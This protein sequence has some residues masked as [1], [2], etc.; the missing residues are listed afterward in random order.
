M[1]CRVFRSA[2]LLCR[3]G[4]LL[5]EETSKLVD[6]APSGIRKRAWRKSSSIIMESLQ[7]KAQKSKNLH[8]ISCN[9]REEAVEM[10]DRGCSLMG[11]IRKRS[12]ELAPYLNLILLKIR[13]N[14]SLTICSKGR[15]R[16]FRTRTM[17]SFQLPS[18]CILE[19]TNWN[20]RGKDRS[21]M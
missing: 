21:K 11:C 10:G 16:I 14:T 6:K 7:S 12:L 3:E 4:M 9:L 20:L 1:A 2:F 13:C 18:K 17:S 19:I 15:F 5:R 8:S